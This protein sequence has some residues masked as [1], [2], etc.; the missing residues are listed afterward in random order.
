MERVGALIAGS[1]W[2]LPISNHTTVMDFRRRVSLVNIG[3]T[4]S[5]LWGDSDEA[6]IASIYHGIHAHHA[7]PPWVKAVWHPFNIPNCSFFMWLAFHNRLMTRDRMIRIGMLVDGNCILCNAQLEC[8]E[9]LLTDCP[10]TNLVMSSM[11]FP[12]VRDWIS[13]MQGHFFRVQLR[14]IQEFVAFLFLSVVGHTIWGERNRRVHNPGKIKTTHQL[15]HHIKQIMRE[16]LS[17]NRRFQKEAAADST[18]I[19]N[20]Y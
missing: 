6:S 17:T 4:D 16:K 10:F 15:V 12:F 5:I 19:L 8:I 18:L 11:D 3:R 1:N 14:K 7:E 2:D 20:M 13:Y 9:H